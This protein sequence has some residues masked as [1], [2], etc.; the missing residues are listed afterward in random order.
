LQVKLSVF[1]TYFKALG[2]PVTLLIVLLLML[3]QAAKVAADVWL[4]DWS[5]EVARNNGTMGPAER[6][7]RLGVYGAFGIIGGKF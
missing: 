2:I 1:F 4:S 6:D 7:R 3:T 5:N